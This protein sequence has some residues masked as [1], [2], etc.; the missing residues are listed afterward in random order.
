MSAGLYNGEAYEVWGPKA[1]GWVEEGGT[2]VRVIEPRQCF[3]YLLRRGRKPQSWLRERAEILLVVG[4]GDTDFHKPGSLRAGAE[5]GETDEKE[6]VDE[7]PR[8]T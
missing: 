6:R 4:P 3:D 1:Q 7:E 8:A 5:E 2:P